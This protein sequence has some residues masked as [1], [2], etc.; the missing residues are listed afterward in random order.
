M[1]GW[2]DHD[3]SDE[4]SGGEELDTISA[5]AEDV[6]PPASIEAEYFATADSTDPLTNEGDSTPQDPQQQDDQQQRR[7]K[8][9]QWPTEAPF[10]AYVGNLSYSL[11]D[12]RQL[13]EE[14][15]RLAKENLGV[16][17]TVLNS[18]LARHR[19][20][21]N[22]NNSG[23]K[24]EPQRHRGFGYV[25]VE[26]LE[27]LQA[28]VEG[29]GGAK[30]AGRSIQ[31]DT[32]NQSQ[33]VGGSNR[34][35]PSWDSNNHHHHHHYKVNDL[36]DG[37]KFREGRYANDDRRRE[38]TEHKDP[39]QQRQGLKLQPRTKPLG[40]DD[41]ASTPKSSIFG[42]GRAR[43]EQSWLERRKNDKAM[44]LNN[45]NNEEEAAEGAKPTTEA[46]TTKPPQ[47][48]Q[49]HRGMRPGRDQTARRA[50]NAGGRGR[51]RERRDTNTGMPQPGGRAT[52]TVP[53]KQEEKKAAYVPPTAEKPVEKTSS[54]S[55][56]SLCGAWWRF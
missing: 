53:A 2:A 34:G 27:Q 4:E 21:R 25:Q 28:I 37:S 36:P 11:D 33:P 40:K 13:G 1:K 43:D 29:L 49:H 48:Q 32:A 46:P 5:S 45:H 17:V 31:L 23:T 42:G 30:L 44:M 18:R 19:N 12:P 9:F 56:Q 26:T 54:G 39:N 8:V 6:A 50:P 7:E 35:K 3:T 55:F 24:D 41:G 51:G 14:I 52:A 38:T 16:D 22:N 10:T 47:Q 20:N 15:T